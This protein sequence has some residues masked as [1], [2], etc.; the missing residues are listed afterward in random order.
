MSVVIYT[1]TGCKYC[2]YLKSF[3]SALDREY[4]EKNISDHYIY[5]EEFQAE[6]VHGVPLTIIDGKKYVGFSSEVKSL[7]KNLK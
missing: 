7:L 5:A 2:D 4:T 1:R 6:K 3:M